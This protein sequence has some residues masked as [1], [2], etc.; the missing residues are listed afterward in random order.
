MLDE[1]EHGQQT[2]DP[3]V[4]VEERVQ[5][6]ELVVQQGVLYEQRD[7]D[8]LVGVALPVSQERRELSW[9]RRDEPRRLDRGS[10]FPNP[11]LGRAELPGRPLATPHSG[12]Q[13]PVHIAD[14]TNT[15][16][17]LAQLAESPFEGVDV[18][19]DLLD[20]RTRRL[21]AC[22]RLKD[23]RQR[24]LRTLDASRGEGLA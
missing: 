3:P 17:E 13:P 20:I 1:Q 8:G 22:L 16:R 11:V 21:A 15:E 9:R 10:T 23:V 5:R 18:V 14:E 19:E 2:P 6:L 12:E 7:L 24:R 4:S